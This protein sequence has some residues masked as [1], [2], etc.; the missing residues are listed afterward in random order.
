MVNEIE[1]KNL[2]GF[3][4]YIKGSLNIQEETKE[5]FISFLLTR[6]ETINLLNTLNQ[7]QNIKEEAL[8]GLSEFELIDND[9]EVNEE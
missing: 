2:N 1:F 8:R 4:N 6:N 5:D 7:Y 9:D 3:I